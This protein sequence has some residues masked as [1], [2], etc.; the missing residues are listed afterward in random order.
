VKTLYSSIEID[1][2]AER[3]WAV[4]TDFAA[5]S[6]WNPFIPR[7][8]GSLEV[9]A[10]LEFH[11]TPPG[12]MAITL[13]PKLLEVE[14]GRTLRWLGRLGVPGIFDGEHH[15]TIEPLAAHRSRLVQ[16]ERF[17]GL[18]VPL[19]AASLD[20]HTLAGFQAMNAALKARAEAAVPAAA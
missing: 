10:R 14:P 17:T 18:L 4:L 16:Q 9:G 15:V 1:A 12:G 20:Q 6:S 5:Y 3:V 13:Q 7:M 19:F 8:T 2:S 11:M